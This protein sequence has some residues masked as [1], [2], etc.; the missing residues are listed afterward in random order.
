MSLLPDLIKHDEFREIKTYLSNDHE[1]SKLYQLARRIGAIFDDYA[2]YRTPMIKRWE[3]S[4]QNGWQPILWNALTDRLG[5]THIGERTESL[6]LARQNSE[7]NRETLPPRISLFGIN[8]MPPL[9]VNILH[10]ISEY[11]D[12]ELYLISPSR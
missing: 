9:Y 10:K 12:I 7:I 3:N 8:S 11:I 2:V 5:K 1:K 6:F 4:D